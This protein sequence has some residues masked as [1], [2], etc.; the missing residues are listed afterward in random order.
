MQ[1]QQV[2]IECSLMIQPIFT[3][4]NNKDF[5]LGLREN[6]WVRIQKVEILRKSFNPMRAVNMIARKFLNNRFGFL[7]MRRMTYLIA[8]SKFGGDGNLN[9][10]NVLYESP[11]L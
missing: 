9:N 10:P 2:R 7:S 11:K 1:I 4:F 6:L 5:G 3:N 8:S